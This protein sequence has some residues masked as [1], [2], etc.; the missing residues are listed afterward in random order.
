ME[1]AMMI[2]VADVGGWAEEDTTGGGGAQSGGGEGGDEQTN[3][4]KET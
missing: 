2:R 3:T 1:Q 4:C